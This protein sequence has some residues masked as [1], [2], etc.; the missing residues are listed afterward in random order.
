M[1]TNDMST[2]NA[3]KRLAE[4]HYWHGVSYYQAGNEDE[5]TKD[6]A[7]AAELGYCPEKKS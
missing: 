2:E 5:A 4:S 7:K 6:Y 1:E 3:K